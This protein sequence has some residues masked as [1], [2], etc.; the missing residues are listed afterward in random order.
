MLIG[1]CFEKIVFTQGCAIKISH[2]K[3]STANPYSHASPFQFKRRDIA[4]DINHNLFV[5]NFIKLSK[6]SMNFHFFAAPEIELSKRMCSVQSFQTHKKGPRSG[7]DTHHTL[8]SRLL[9]IWQGRH[10]DSPTWKISAFM[11]FLE[12]DCQILYCRYRQSEKLEHSILLPTRVTKDSAQPI[13]DHPVI[14]YYASVLIWRLYKMNLNPQSWGF[15]FSFMNYL[16]EGENQSGLEQRILKSDP[17]KNWPLP[18][19]EKVN[20]NII[21]WTIFKQFLKMPKQQLSLCTLS[22]SQIADDL[23]LKKKTKSQ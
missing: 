15:I 19:H 22:I 17:T 23:F 14:S 2:R 8:V 13:T 16:Q 3:C 4:V 12:R 6:S 20:K 18:I 10:W 5:E 21:I 11:L 1:E 7:Q 9:E